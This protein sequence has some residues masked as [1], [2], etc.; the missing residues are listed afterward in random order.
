VH[1]TILLS[2]DPISGMNE[3]PAPAS[4]SKHISKAAPTRHYEDDNAR[5]FGH[6]Y[7]QRSHGHQMPYNN[8]VRP[9][10]HPIFFARP[11]PQFSAGYGMFMPPVALPHIKG[12]AGPAVGFAPH[13]FSH[14]PIPAIPMFAH[15][16]YQP[17]QR[18]IPPSFPP[19]S[20]IPMPDFGM[21]P[22]ENGMHNPFRRS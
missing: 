20:W 5:S 7:G 3:S 22:V 9:Q 4:R 14:Y 12:Q 1:D 8:F 16:S 18:M 19:D 2:S 6:A 11:P 17:Y 13:A 10:P 21:P 15:P